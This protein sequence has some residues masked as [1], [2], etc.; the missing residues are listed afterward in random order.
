MDYVMNTRADH[1]FNNKLYVIL[2]VTT[3]LI[4]SYSSASHAK[5]SEIKPIILSHYIFHET[6]THPDHIHYGPHH[7]HYVPQHT[8]V[9]PT[10]VLEHNFMYWTSWQKISRHCY[11][12]C[13]IDRLGRTV[14][15]SNEC[16]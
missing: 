1:F 10:P 7:Y 8:H 14:R 6:I 16:L 9:T 3:L 12:S 2:I 15:C 11:R 4:G 13:L 5:P